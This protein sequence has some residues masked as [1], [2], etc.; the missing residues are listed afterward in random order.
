MT[1]PYF[2]LPEHEL[3]QLEAEAHSRW[4]EICNQIAELNQEAQ[5]TQEHLSMIYIAK[6]AVGTEARIIQFPERV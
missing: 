1:N 3:D 4:S 5:Q 2:E 6:L